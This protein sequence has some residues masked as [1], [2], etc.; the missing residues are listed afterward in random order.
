MYARRF[1]L[2]KRQDCFL[3]IALFGGSVVS[4]KRLSLQKKLLTIE[5]DL[6]MLF[7][8]LQR[9]EDSASPLVF[10]NRIAVDVSEL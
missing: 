6:S 3:G 9:R 7:V 1:V 10:E 8:W 5:T 4:K 2:L